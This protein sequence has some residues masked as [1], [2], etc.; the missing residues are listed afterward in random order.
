MR[1]SFRQ[2][3]RAAAFFV[4]M[5][6][7]VAASSLPNLNWA[8]N[9]SRGQSI[10][11]ALE[12]APPG[13]KLTLTVRGTCNEYV[14]ID[15]DDVTL[16]GDPAWGAVLNG[17]EAN[18]NVIRVE[19][20]RVRIDNLTVQGGVDGINVYGTSNVAITRAVIQNAAANGITLVNSHATVIDSTIEHSGG[21]GIYLRGASA[22]LGKNEIRLNS[23]AGV[24]LEGAS[25]E[26]NGN[27]ITS[28]GSNGV[29]LQSGSRATMNANMIWTNGSNPAGRGNGV[30]VSFS[31]ADIRGGNGISS[32]RQS[33]V[34]ADGSTVTIV[35]SKVTAN[36]LG[37]VQVYLG[38]TLAISG[39]AVSLNTDNGVRLN[40]NSTGQI[41]GAAIQ[42]NTGDGILLMFGST[43]R[44]ED[45]TT[46]ITGN[47]GFGLQCSDGESSVVGTFRFVF[48]PPNAR[49]GV[50]ATCEVVY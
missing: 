9:C 2:A 6:Y 7:V 36:G 33:G 34:A 15:R 14:L 45:P 21:D 49:G 23:G 43:L 29:E 22:L 39:G 41:A 18:A 40:T 17:P 8:V 46:V 20:N 26:A 35:D 24:H 48:N 13:I 11:R 30:F 12:H 38:S 50:S 1:I 32:N 31:H 25:I 3:A 4:G 27:T 37:G 10:S 19:G 42:N 47:G 16:Q 44:V 28:N 5:T